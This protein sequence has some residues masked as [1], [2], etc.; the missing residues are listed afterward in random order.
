MRD[1]FNID[2]DQPPE[3][4]HPI[5]TVTDPQD[6]DMEPIEDSVG[7]P[8]RNLLLKRTASGPN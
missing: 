2:S 4:G 6:V 5:V 1:N 3:V 8:V 7:D